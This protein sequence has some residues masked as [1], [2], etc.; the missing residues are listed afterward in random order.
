MS[1]YTELYLHCVWATWDRLPLVNEDI[2]RALYGAIAQVCH[3][4]KCE[5]LAIGGKSDHV[6]VLV[7]LATTVSIAE[8]LKAM[9]GSSSHLMTH[10]VLGKDDFFKWQGG[11]G[12]FTLSKRHVPIVTNY[13]KN[14]KT[15]HSENN[16]WDEFEKTGFP[17]ENE[18]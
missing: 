1:T 11:Y 7:H 6:H 13:V 8:L 12:A 14:Q 3:D 2:E 10:N 16:L 9:K 5:V 18:H 17:E 4:L 15:H